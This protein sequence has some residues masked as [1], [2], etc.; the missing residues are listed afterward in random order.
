MG[1]IIFQRETKTHLLTVK[2]GPYDGI[3]FFETLKYEGAKEQ[4]FSI[5][6]IEAISISVFVLAS[7][8]D[9]LMEFIELIKEQSENFK[10]NIL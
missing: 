9:E 4:R 10:Q 7:Y 5:S 6:K 2:K 1:K 3:Q 8:P